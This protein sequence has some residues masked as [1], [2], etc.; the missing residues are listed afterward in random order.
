MKIIKSNTAIQAASGDDEIFTLADW[1]ESLNGD[2]YNT[3]YELKYETGS[4]GDAVI[5]DV[6]YIGDQSDMMPSIS[7]QVVWEGDTAYVEVEIGEFP[8][9]DSTSNCDYA[10]SASYWFKRWADEAGRAY[11]ILT[12]ASY[13]FDKYNDI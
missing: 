9:L 7:A 6:V 13:S 8:R 11:E 3:K 2:L 1:L 12:K 10:D 5:R 4:E